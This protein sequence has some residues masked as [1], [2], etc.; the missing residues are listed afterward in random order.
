MTDTKGI[1]GPPPA[2]LIERTERSLSTAQTGSGKNQ[3]PSGLPSQAGEARLS[4]AGS[5]LAA[6]STGEDVRTD[7]VAA[8]KAAI[9]AGSYQVSAS[10]VA[11][12]LIH[13]MLE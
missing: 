9:D 7:K 11:D 10:D 1:S 12:K 5:V 4:G 6:A 13:T 2:T 3:E 8:L